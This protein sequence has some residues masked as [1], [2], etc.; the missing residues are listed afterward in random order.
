MNFEKSNKK[1]F[2][3]TEKNFYDFAVNIFCLS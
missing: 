2:F 1:R 3:Y